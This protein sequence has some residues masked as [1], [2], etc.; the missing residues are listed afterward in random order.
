MSI[1]ETDLVAFLEAQSLPC[2][3]RVYPLELP[4]TPTLPALVFGQVSTVVPTQTH[5]RRL[6]YSLGR[7]QFDCYAQYY[8]DA[9]GLADA[10]VTAMLPWAAHEVY[11]ENMLDLSEFE[12]DR[13]RVT[14]EFVIGGAR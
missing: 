13:Y 1:I 11:F 10:L 3:E 4:Q 9:K 5:D 14:V 6:V 2:G 8:E 12:L 7:Y